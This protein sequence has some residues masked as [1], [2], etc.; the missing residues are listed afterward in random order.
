MP[1]PTPYENAIDLL[2]ADHKAVKQLFIQY[3]AL[4]E[5]GAP[6]E[7]K[8]QLA[9]KICN[10]IAIHAQIEEEIF[11]PEVRKATGDDALID[12]A[13]QEHAAAKEA[14]AAIQG[15]SAGG[16]GYDEAVQ[17][18]ARLIDQHVLEE[19]EQIFLQAQY[20]A[21]DLRG[22]AEPLARRKA[23]LKKKSA[24]KKAKEAA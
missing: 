1:P 2:D 5:D 8:Q 10:E 15:M 22:L 13:Q 21:L 3:D 24:P 11:Y 18:L 23:Q 14:V 20:A 4:C 16:E 6:A 19:R 12:E 9:E 17:G 7:D